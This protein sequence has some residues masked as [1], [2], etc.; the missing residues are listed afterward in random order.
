MNEMN[1]IERRINGGRAHRSIAEIID[2]GHIEGLERAR[3][4]GHHNTLAAH[5]APSTSSFFLSNV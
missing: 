4:P 5:A 3:D 2:E 1:L